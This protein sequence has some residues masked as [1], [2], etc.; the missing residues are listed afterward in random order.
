M[1]SYKVVAGGNYVIDKQYYSWLAGEDDVLDVLGLD[2]LEIA[3]KSWTCGA[4]VWSVPCS[5]V[6]VVA[7]YIPNILDEDHVLN[8]SLRL[9]FS[10]KVI[11]N[12]SHSVLQIV[13]S[14][15]GRV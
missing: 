6:G 13:L 15:V 7:R 5:R 11:N 4:G 8:I 10:V 1:L 3:I 9:P 2:S 14:V 12:I